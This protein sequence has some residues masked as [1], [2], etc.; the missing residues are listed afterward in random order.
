MSVLRSLGYVGTPRVKQTPEEKADK[1]LRSRLW[2]LYRIT[3][4]Q[5]VAVEESMRIHGMTC[6]LGTSLKGTGTD[7]DHNT[8][9][10]RGRLAFL[11]NKA[12][13]FVDAHAKTTG[14]TPTQI[15]QAMARYASIPPA[16][17]AIGY[18]YGLIGKAQRKRKMIYG[19]AN[20]PLPPVVTPKK[21]NKKPAK[22]K[23]YVVNMSKGDGPIGN[24]D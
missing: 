20:G 9:L 24:T 10:Y 4:E 1:A 17:T 2:L 8:G 23:T 6:L 3:P 13:G 11:I 18:H 16:V 7:H 12:M 14:M 19:S 15:L 22:K 21:P 5:Q